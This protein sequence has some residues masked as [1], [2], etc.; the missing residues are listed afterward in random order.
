M[1]RVRDPVRIG[2]KNVVLYQLELCR[3]ALCLSEHTNWYGLCARV[4]KF[5]GFHLGAE[6]SRWSVGYGQHSHI[7]TCDS[8]ARTPRRKARQRKPLVMIGAPDDRRHPSG[9]GVPSSGAAPEPGEKPAEVR[10]MRAAFL[11]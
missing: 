8:T 9:L 2:R 7:A 4:K 10:R 6:A 1:L 11:G 3:R 5:A